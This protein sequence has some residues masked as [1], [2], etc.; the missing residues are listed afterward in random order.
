MIEQ[1]KEKQ[2]NGEGNVPGKAS[3]KCKGPVV[4]GKSRN[5]RVPAWVGFREWGER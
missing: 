1:N 3:S 2:C 4:R 5:P